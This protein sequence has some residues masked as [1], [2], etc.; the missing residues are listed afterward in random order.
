MAN[1]RQAAKRARQNE[2]R[3]LHNTSQ[4]T[5]VR[6]AIKSTI[7]AINSNSKDAAETAF[8]QATKLVDKIAQRRI[9]S[10]NKAAR[11][12]SRLSKKIKSIA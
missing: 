11:I 4:H 2:K 1:T 7:K 6:T 9:I 8:K 10:A 3:R 12:K 5:R